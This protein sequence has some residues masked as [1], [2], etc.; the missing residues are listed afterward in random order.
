MAAASTVPAAA[1]GPAAPAGLSQHLVFRIGDVSAALPVVDI[2]EV[3]RRP[4]VL[5][6]PLSPPAVEGLM[7]LRGTVTVLIDM[8]RALGQ[9]EAAAG[10]GVRVVVLGGGRRIGLQVDRIAGMIGSAPGETGEEA[11][12][13]AVSLLDL[14]RVLP[15][16]AA[17]AAR[18]AHL[19]AG[20]QRTGQG[21]GQAAVPVRADLAAAETRTLVTFEADGEEYAIPVSAVREIVR[22]QAGVARMPHAD[23]HNLGVMTL[24]GRLLPL[25]DLRSLLGLGA[26]VAGRREDAAGRIIVLAFGGL[27][28]GLVVDRA[29][30]ILRVPNDRIDPVPALFRQDS[31]EIEAICRLDQGRRLISILD[32]DRLFRTEAVRRTLA[33]GAGPG[34][35]PNGEQSGV[36]DMPDPD[37]VQRSAQ[38]T[39]ATTTFVIF[40][41]GSVEYGLPSSCVEQVVAVPEQLTAV[42]KAPAFIEG[43]INHRGA[44]LPVIDQR[45][46]FAMTGTARSRHIVVAALGAAR[47]GVMVDAVTGVLK[48][49]EE[50]IEPAPD[51]SAE[52]IALISRVATLDGRMILL[53]DP[54]HLLARGEAAEIA[55]LDDTAASGDIPA[56]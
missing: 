43:V 11:G 31:G 17:G 30:E 28:V 39:T 22:R 50:A 2:V 54:A 16:I 15:R 34:T 48:I 8:R 38:T 26:S 23:G 1:G 13:A 14:D 5:P 10:E 32:P 41:L 24:R 44:V 12:E 4:E 25:V 42:P 49:P 47:A 45:R 6:V 18:P 36:A 51:L 52:Q 33:G 35:E 55:A 7:N 56:P 21:A 46:R 40:R 27:E 29:R 19:S 37:A 3:V 9:P 53:L 20:A